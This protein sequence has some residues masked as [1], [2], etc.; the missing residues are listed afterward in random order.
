MSMS[1]FLSRRALKPAAH[2]GMPR[3]QDLLFIKLCRSA[4]DATDRSR[5]GGWWKW[6]RTSRS[7]A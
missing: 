3:W 5:R 7:K 1:F 2:S 4:N 6:E